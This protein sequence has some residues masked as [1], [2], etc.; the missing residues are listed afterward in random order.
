MARLT[1]TVA[2]LIADARNR[3]G[4]ES[5]QF[6]TDSDIRRY[7]EESGFKMFGK[8]DAQY[9]GAYYLFAS[10]TIAV[11]SGTALYDL[12]DGCFKPIAFRVTIDG[13][14][15]SIPQA[16]IDEIDKDVTSPGWA[17]RWP[18]HRVMGFSTASPDETQ[19]MFTPTPTA[20]HTVT[21]WYI[22]QKP[23]ILTGS[24]DT[25]DDDLDATNGKITTEWN[26]EEY[27]VLDTA[28]KIK[29]DQ[30]EDPRAIMMERQELW[31]MIELQVANRTVTEAPRVRDVYSDYITDYYY[32]RRRYY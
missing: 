21:C 16:N 30:E 13:V 9:P 26:W 20:S 2:Q 19:V 1:R 28:I 4:L 32:P 27:I 6:R 23:F 7:L 10:D 31:E 3:S 12:P 8:I 29:N 24:P 25:R 22:P 14:R 15:E 17:S 5:C 18:R 11:S